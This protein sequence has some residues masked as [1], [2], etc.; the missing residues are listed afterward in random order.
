MRLRLEIERSKPAK[1]ESPDTLGRGL[2]RVDAALVAAQAGLNAGDRGKVQAASQ[3]L[4]AATGDLQEWV[5]RSWALKTVP[6]FS[7]AS[8]QKRVSGALIEDICGTE[9]L[10]SN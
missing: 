3:E 8:S 6:Q 5:K 1:N 9:I 10:V 2:G 4:T 7:W